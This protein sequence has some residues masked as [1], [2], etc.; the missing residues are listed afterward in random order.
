MINSDTSISLFSEARLTRRGPSSVAL[1]VLTHGAGIALISM[2]IMLAPPNVVPRPPQRYIMRL[3]TLNSPEEQAR[4]AAADNA[5]YPDPDKAAQ[6]QPPGGKPESQP[7]IADKIARQT[8]IQPDAPP[9]VK[10]PDDTPLPKV[11][12]WQKPK[13]ELK[14]VVPDPPKLPAATELKPSI[15]VPNQEVDLSDIRISSTPFVA[16]TLQVTPSNVSPIVNH[17]PDTN[18]KIPETASNASDN[19]APAQVISLSDM[20]MPE[21]TTALPF[22]S[23]TASSEYS[24]M[25]NGKDSNNNGAG[26]PNS[27]AN[28]TGAGN[29]ASGAPGQN[30]SQASNGTG[31]S[32][33]RFTTPKNGH[34]SVV[35]TGTSMDELY[36]ETAGMWGNRIAY[37]VY[38]HVG[39]AKNWILQYSIPRGEEA[40]N[41][42]SVVKPDPP[43]PTDI[44]RPNLAAGEINADALLVHGF[45]NEDGRFEKLTV[46]FPPQFPR[47]KFVLDALNQ[48]Q[49][50]P[51]QQLGLPVRVEVLLIVP[52]TLE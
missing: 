22:A 20:N 23:Q 39:A 33:T 17:A 49:F 5:K 10:L 3:L 40:A 16:E 11:V 41:G 12:S 1:S 4:Q 24:G 38:L 8:L 42:G 26:N 6:K 44:T 14:E 52:E 37:T 36:P 2:G 15:E 9:D 29:S 43:W 35:I 21:G 34:Y 27:N 30:A 25:G 13:V 19:P 18:N 45:V 46:V 31:D 28:G 7:S 48:W 47:A 32:T 51:A 50:R